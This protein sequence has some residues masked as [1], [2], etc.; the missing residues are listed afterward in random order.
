MKSVH[1][2]QE[3]PKVSVLDN[4][5]FNY[6]EF[7]GKREKFED[8]E[9]TEEHKKAIISFLNY[10]SINVTGF[11]TIVSMGRFFFYTSICISRKNIVLNGINPEYYNSCINFF[12]NLNLH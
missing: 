4:R 12:D 2:I 3:Y 9:L 5:N 7:F 11:Y 6:S 8:K 10:G 1:A